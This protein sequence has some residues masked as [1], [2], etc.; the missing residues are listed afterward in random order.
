MPPISLFVD[1]V[2]G[3]VDQT[4]SGGYVIALGLV[5]LLQ[6]V[7]YL[8]RQTKTRQHLDL[9]RR[10][11][12]GMHGELNSA[13]KDQT[14]ASLENHILREFVEQ[15]DIDQAMT[16]LLRRFIPDPHRGFAAFVSFGSQG[17]TIDRSRGLSSESLDGLHVDDVL[18][19]RVEREQIVMLSG[20][21]LIEHGLL[22]DI[23]QVDRG[24]VRRL[25]LIGIGTDDR[26]LITTALYPAGASQ[27]QQFELA[28]RLMAG[29][30]GGIRHANQL[31]A[32]EDQLR[33]ASEMLELRSIADEQYQTPLEMLE[34]F[35]SCLREKTGSDR[36]ALHLVSAQTGIAKRALLR[37]GGTH[38]S[39]VESRHREYESMLARCGIVEAEPTAFDGDDLVRLG[40]A[41]LVNSALVTPLAKGDSTIGV[42]CFTR[43]GRVPFGR[44]ERDL[45]SWAAEYIADTIVR[46][47]NQAAVE[48]Q[49]R[50]DG[51]TELANRREFDRHSQLELKLAQQAGRECSL[52]LIDLDRFKSINDTYGHQAGDEVLRVTAAV[53]RD[54]VSRL[55]AEDRALIAR[56]GGEEMVVLLPGIGLGGANRI[57]EMI[58]TG[59]QNARIEYRGQV[60]QVTASVGIAI[61]PGHGGTMN[62]LIAAADAALYQAKESGRNRVCCAA[63][64]AV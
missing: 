62:E 23:A 14:L 39:G 33:L 6:Y 29:I 44:C 50:Q 64:V 56:Y 58:R 46:V 4:V 30:A 26:L 7:V 12:E 38:Q 54:E 32:Q 43:S 3:F 17:S 55:R 41:S 61:H 21:E 53:L 2:I 9:C 16:V 31:R 22:A 20:A 48:R 37:C 10:E 57:A 19:V 47:L 45:A 13:H 8:N 27:E 42:I 60:L 24:K 63:P 5:C 35:L 25:Y 49:A 18:R 51:L 34:A 28:R 52:L 40:I 11:M 36:A 15:T 59:V 1:R